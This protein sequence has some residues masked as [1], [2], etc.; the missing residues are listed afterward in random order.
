MSILEWVREA[1][2]KLLWSWY[3]LLQREGECLTR[4]ELNQKSEDSLKDY[5]QEINYKQCK[6][7]C[8]ITFDLVPFWENLHCIYICA[9]GRC[10]ILTL[11]INCGAKG[12]SAKMWNLIPLKLNKRAD[13]TMVSVSSRRSPQATT[14]RCMTSSARLR[15]VTG[16]ATLLCHLLKKRD[17]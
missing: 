11:F 6:G 1:E 16:G 13:L 14:A 3:H 7:F 15:L 5:T 4:G 9:S 10:R 2:L 12:S 8:A 17:K